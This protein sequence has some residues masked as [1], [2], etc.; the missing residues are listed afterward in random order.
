MSFLAPFACGPPLLLGGANDTNDAEEERPPRLALRMAAADAWMEGT[1][2]AAAGEAASAAWAV[3]LL[4]LRAST[5][6]VRLLWRSAL[7]L[8]VDS[9]NRCIAATQK[10]RGVRRE[11]AQQGNDE[12]SC[13]MSAAV[14]AGGWSGLRRRSRE[15]CATQQ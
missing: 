4:T 5:D 14:G 10:R 3:V 11:S 9:T 7:R 13:K 1:E 6:G 8:P 12:G 2:D 15:R